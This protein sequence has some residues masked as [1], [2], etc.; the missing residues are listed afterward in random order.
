MALRTPVPFLSD[1]EYPAASFRQL[2]HTMFGRRSG[3]LVGSGTELPSFG[4][5]PQPTPDMSVRVGR[6]IAVLAGSQDTEQGSYLLINDAVETVPI[7]PASTVNDRIDLVGLAV[8]DGDY[9]AG[10]STAEIV[11]LAGAPAANP[12]R[13]TPDPDVTF[14]PLAEVVVPAKTSVITRDQVHDL[15]TFTAAQGGIQYTVQSEFDHPG[16]LGQLRYIPTHG[17]SPVQVFHSGRWRGITSTVYQ[18]TNIRVYNNT[19][20][21]RLEL[22]RLSIPDPGYPYVVD[23]SFRYEYGAPGGTRYDGHVVVDNLSQG[24]VVNVY[25]GQGPTGDVRTAVAAT[26]SSHVLTGPHTLILRASRI[27]G[28]GGLTTTPY[29]G[30]FQARIFPAP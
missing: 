29:N 11:V 19:A 10:D 6:G 7:G 1:V 8:R 16:F 14:L 5:V 21:D 24:A 25:V 27:Y 22:A 30:L 9:T 20:V 3:V 13:P 15:R 18:T 28:T 2:L 26:Q 17:I 12:E 23:T 4:V